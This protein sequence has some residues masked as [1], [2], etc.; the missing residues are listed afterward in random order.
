MISAG[1]LSMIACRRSSLARRS[2]SARRRSVMSTS[3][4]EEVQRPLA[5]AVHERDVH[6]RVDHASRRRAG[7]ASRSR[8]SAGARPAA[9]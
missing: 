3:W 6:E 2:A 8:T 1:E 4:H 7:S 9:P 5:V